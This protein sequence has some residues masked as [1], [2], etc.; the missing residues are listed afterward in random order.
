YKAIDKAYAEYKRSLELV[1]RLEE[2][3]GLAE[4]DRAA[5]EAGLRRIISAADTPETIKIEAFDL[6]IELDPPSL[7]ET[8]RQDVDRARNESP[9]GTRDFFQEAEV[10]LSRALKEFSTLDHDT[11]E[12]LRTAEFLYV[13]TEK[14]DHSVD[15]SRSIGFSYCFAVENE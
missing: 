10:N 2:L 4:S 6:L 9:L 11:Q 13:H 5:C 12:A 3:R 15:F 1:A 14:I 8:S 7:V